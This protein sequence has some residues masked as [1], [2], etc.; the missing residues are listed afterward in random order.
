MTKNAKLSDSG[1]H[2]DGIQ[3]YDDRQLNRE[4]F[5][6]LSDNRYITEPRNIILVGATG[7]G[8]SY[9]ACALGNNACQSAIKV[10]YYRLPDLL[11]ELKLARAQDTYKKTL[12]Q[13]Q[14]CELLLLDEWLLIPASD[15][16]QQDLL[17]VLERRYRH[18]ATIFCSQFGTDGW[19]QRLGGD[20][21]A[22]AILDRILSK[23]KLIT[24]QGDKSMR[25]R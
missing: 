21:L 16:E 11:T 19:H 24:I 8:K 2:I 15:Q 12:R 7:S 23:S 13:L 6:N 4:T 1:A 10:K 5:L 25:K 17:E 22:D 18:Q 20:A 9:I 3:Y 14:N